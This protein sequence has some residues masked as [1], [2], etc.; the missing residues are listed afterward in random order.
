[1][2]LLEF[3][4]VPYLKASAIAKK[5]G[6][7]ADYVG[8]LCRSGKVEAK[9]VGRTWYVS[10]TSIKGHKSSRNRSSK[11]KTQEALKVSIRKDA[12][13]RPTGNSSAAPAAV[14]KNFY[15]KIPEQKFKYSEDGAELIP[16]LSKK[17]DSV[18]A[19]VAVVHADAKPL[20]ISD[21]KPSYSLTATE[22]KPI[23]FTG[24]LSVTEPTSQV[25]ESEQVT[26]PIKLDQ[27]NSAHDSAVPAR[28]RSHRGKLHIH[29]VSVADN[30]PKA[31]PIQ[32]DVGAL[33]QE[34]SNRSTKNLFSVLIWL[35]V[36]TS[37]LGT[38]VAITAAEATTVFEGT[39]VTSYSFDISGSIEKIR[40]KI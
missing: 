5:L 17:P 6:Y 22:K 38:A 34:S 39:S 1:M 3:E 29:H 20:K 30:S 8:Q 36:L 21:S 18:R 7:T 27:P 16:V 14:V 35:L 13:D 15:K 37:A 9:L 12:V 25:V 33:R 24:K 23:K 2:D 11:S 26:N 10:E 40:F 28:E 4:G 32:L 31:V 19:K